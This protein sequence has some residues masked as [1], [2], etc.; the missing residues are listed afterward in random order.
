MKTRKN[1]AIAP[2]SAALWGMVCWVGLAGCS[3]SPEVT[4]AKPSAPAAAR[5]SA[6]Q[7]PPGEWV[8]LFDGKTLAGWKVPQFGGS[9]KVY[10][11]DGV[12]HIGIGQGCTGITYDP[13]DPRAPLSSLPRENY[14]VQLE[15]ERLEGVDFFC[16]LTFPVGK[17]YITLVCAGWGGAVTGLS[18][19][20]GYDASDNETT[21]TIDYKNNRWYAIRCRVTKTRIQCW[22]DGDR[23]I[24]LPRKG[25]EISVREE[26]EPSRP[27]GIATWQ[28][29]GAVRDIQIRKLPKGIDDELP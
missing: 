5:R 23:I 29:H 27:L 10:V 20:D 17:D 24:D 18:C 14:E 19:L 26:V 22:I 16:G 3:K 15:A 6:E 13:N 11:K 4:A 9:G 2:W 1:I 8:T 7:L 28:T 12:I 21:Q 25:K